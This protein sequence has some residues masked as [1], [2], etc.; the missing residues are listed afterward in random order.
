M[1]NTIA[2]F[3]ESLGLR[4]NP[5]VSLADMIDHLIKKY[6]VNPHSLVDDIK[7]AKIEKAKVCIHRLKKSN[8]IGLTNYVQCTI[9]DIKYHCETC[10]MMSQPQSIN[11]SM[12]NI[13]HHITNGKC[14][15]CMNQIEYYICDKN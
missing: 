14:C 1:S 6:R 2:D 5:E 9:C 3:V 4:T 13:G 15:E 12:T 11:N 8:N 7:N 10:A